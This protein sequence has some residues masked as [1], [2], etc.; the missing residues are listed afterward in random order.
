M[1]PKIS[2]TVV[3]FVG[4]S[5]YKFKGDVRGKKSPLQQKTQTI[6]KWISVADLADEPTSEELCQPII[7]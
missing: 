4:H 5:I 3:N 7:Y 6:W 2:V 1:N